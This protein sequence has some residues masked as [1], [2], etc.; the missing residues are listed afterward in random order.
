MKKLLATVILLAS[1]RSAPA[2][3]QPEQ[4]QAVAQQFGQ[5]MTCLSVQVASGTVAANQAT[6]MNTAYGYRSIEVQN[7][8]GS[9][10]LFCGT[11][12][13]VSSQP[14][15]A[16]N[17]ATGWE[18]PGAATMPSH[19]FYL[20]PGQILYCVNDSGSKVTFATVCKGR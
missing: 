12:I 7:R 20:V 14:G 18:I 16:F 8:D 6:A 11:A 5:V 17:A 1:F 19:T 3:A 10:N 9:A 4:V 13:S 2:L 15:S